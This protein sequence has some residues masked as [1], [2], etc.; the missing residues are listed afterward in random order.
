MTLTVEPLYKCGEKTEDICENGY[1]NNILSS[2]HAHTHRPAQLIYFLSQM[3]SN[4]I[5]LAICL[6]LHLHLFPHIIKKNGVHVYITFR[7]CSNPFT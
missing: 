1:V 4:L 5:T 3:F 6:T 2:Y 7:L